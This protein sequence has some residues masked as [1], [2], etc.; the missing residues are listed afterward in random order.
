M[1]SAYPYSSNMGTLTYSIPVCY[2]TNS[3]NDQWQSMPHAAT[4]RGEGN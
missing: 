4:D 3:Q 1:L 2:Q